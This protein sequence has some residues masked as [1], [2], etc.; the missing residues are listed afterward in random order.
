[1][2]K[3]SAVRSHIIRRLLK[4]ASRKKGILD[5]DAHQKLTFDRSGH[6]SF[7]HVLL[8]EE[9]YKDHR[10]RTDNAYRVD[11]T[12]VVREFSQISQGD[13]Y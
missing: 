2:E 12:P 13:T 4:P 6:K 1:M 8:E 5:Q 11:Q 10:D 9:E 7:Y 3:M